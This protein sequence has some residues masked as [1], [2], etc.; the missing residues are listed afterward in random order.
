MS[1]N[2]K[3]SF[4]KDAAETRTKTGTRARANVTG[5]YPLSDENLTP[6]L[7]FEIEPL[8]SLERYILSE[9]DLANNLDVFSK[10]VEQY[11][12]T[13]L[14]AERLWQQDFKGSQKMNNFVNK[15]ELF[16]EIEYW[17]DNFPDSDE[18]DESDYSDDLEDSIHLTR[19]RFCNGSASTTIKNLNTRQEEL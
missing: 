15:I 12:D 11:I 6:L 5:E 16:C 4:G 2:D 17:D 1:S 8:R 9:L 7:G 18:D 3:S 14:L 13:F 10:S 19:S